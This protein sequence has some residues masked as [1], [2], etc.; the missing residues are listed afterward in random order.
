MSG[1]TDN[2][3]DIDLNEILSEVNAGLSRA[4]GSESDALSDGGFSSDGAVSSDG[5]TSDEVS[6]QYQIN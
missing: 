4:R 1:I 3:R 5:A 6:N 2:W